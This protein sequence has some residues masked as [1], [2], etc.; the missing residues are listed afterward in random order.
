VEDSKHLMS[1][2]KFAELVRLFVWAQIVGAWIRT[3]VEHMRN[4]LSR[5]AFAEYIRYVQFV[6]ASLEAEV[7]ARYPIARDNRAVGAVISV[8][9]LLAS[10]MIAAI[11]FSQL[12]AQANAI[13]TA[14]NDTAALNFISSTTTT[15]WSA[16]NLYVI[17]AIVMAAGFILALLAAWGKQGGSGV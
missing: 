16:L 7:Y 2:R 11:V 10:L 5:S 6:R 1:T 12:A 9:I 13:A 3:F 17:A 14:N 15:G 8:I 4:R